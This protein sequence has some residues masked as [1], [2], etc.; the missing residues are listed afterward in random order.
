MAPS[1][2][3]IISNVTA[4][5]KSFSLDFAYS[6]DHLLKCHLVCLSCFVVRSTMLH[7]LEFIFVWLSNFFVPAIY[8]IVSCIV[9]DRCISFETCLQ[10]VA[11][12]LKTWFLAGFEWNL[13]VKMLTHFS[14]SVVHSLFHS[15]H[16][17]VNL[18]ELGVTFCLVTKNGTDTALDE[19]DV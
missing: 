11:D 10:L 18:S 14:F 9:F 6:G 5:L 13:Y 7:G 8:D 12:L 17:L 15:I 3:L 1:T 16:I 4:L 19:S 2:Q